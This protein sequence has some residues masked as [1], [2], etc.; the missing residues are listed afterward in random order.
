MLPRHQI[1]VIRLKRPGAHQTHQHTPFTPRV[2][3][4]SQDSSL[5]CIDAKL[6]YSS[7]AV[8]C[9]AAGAYARTPCTQTTKR[10]G[11][12]PARSHPWTSSASNVR[13]R[14]GLQLDPAVTDATRAHGHASSPPPATARPAVRA[15]ARPGPMNSKRRETR[16]PARRAAVIST[17]RPRRAWPHGSPGARRWTETRSGARFW[18][19]LRRRR[20]TRSRQTGESG[21][22]DGEPRTDA[23]G[24][25]YGGRVLLDGRPLLSEW[26]L[27]PWCLSE[28]RIFRKVAT[29]DTVDREVPWTQ[30]VRSF[31][32]FR[33]E[34]RS[35]VQY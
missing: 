34:T 30:P 8:P 17:G 13:V 5:H 20:R 4:C 2:F 14:V 25:V 27:L 1:S 12:P 19:V 35:D 32:P 7:R 9:G 26:S 33:S 15:P 3:H 31:S 11:P 23:G 18:S 29:C 22:G 24:S 10:R 21:G 6:D 28:F 16:G